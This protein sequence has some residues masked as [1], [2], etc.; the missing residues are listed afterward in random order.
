M[1]YGIKL[2]VYLK[3]NLIVEKEFDSEPS[4]TDKYIKTKVSMCNTLFL[5]LIVSKKIMLCMEFCFI[6]K[7]Y[8]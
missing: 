1:Q 6:T 7:F 8:C 3:K 5:G 2:E 4:Y